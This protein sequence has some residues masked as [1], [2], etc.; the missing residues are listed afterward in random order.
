MLLGKKKGNKR[1]YQ[2][3]CFPLQHNLKPPALSEGCTMVGK[4]GA[5]TNVD[6]GQR[7]PHSQLRRTGFD[8]GAD[9]FRGL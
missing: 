9:A 1:F 6:T 8:G 5:R 3:I 7:Q 2:F 4:M